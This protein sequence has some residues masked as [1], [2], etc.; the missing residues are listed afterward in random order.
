MEELEQKYQNI[1]DNV[2]RFR[3][4]KQM[5][6]EELAKL[7]NVSNAYISQ[8]E[9]ANLHKSVTCQTLLNIAKA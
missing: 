8:I 6:Q 7:S 4:M 1:G 9:R 3:I 2:Y 5:T